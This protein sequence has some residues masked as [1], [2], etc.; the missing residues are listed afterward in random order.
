MSASYRTISKSISTASDGPPDAATSAHQNAA[1][2]EA[3]MESFPASDPVAV[4]FILVSSD[5][6][7]KRMD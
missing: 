2:D 5:M 7:E 4:N 6:V 1:L 3:L